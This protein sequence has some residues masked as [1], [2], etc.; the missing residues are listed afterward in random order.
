MNV[1]LQTKRWVVLAEMM[2][3]FQMKSRTAI[4]RW[5][6]EGMPSHQLLAA[7]GGKGFRAF[8]IIEV[9]NWCQRNGRALP[10]ALAMHA[11]RVQDNEEEGHTLRYDDAVTEIVR[12]S[13]LRAPVLKNRI[14]SV[15]RKPVRDD[16]RK[17]GSRVRTNFLG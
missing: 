7:P 5:M 9:V 8:D 1:S 13:V 15:K 10:L 3:L 6:E 17:S 16:S 2:H 4:Y 12:G 14:S 11:R